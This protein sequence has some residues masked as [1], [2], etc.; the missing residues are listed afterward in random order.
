MAEG[1]RPRTVGAEALVASVASRSGSRSRRTASVRFEIH[2]V[3]LRDGCEERV[4]GDPAQGLL[5]LAPVVTRKIRQRRS[6][7]VPDARCEKRPH[8]GVGREGKKMLLGFGRLQAFR[9]LSTDFRLRGS[10]RELE[11]DLGGDPDPVAHQPLQ[12]ELADE[13]LLG[14]LCQEGELFGGDTAPDR[15]VSDRFVGG[16]RD[17]ENERRFLVEKCNGGRSLAQGRGIERQPD[18]AL[19]ARNRDR[20]F[21]SGLRRRELGIAKALRKDRIWRKDKHGPRKRRRP[22]ARIAW[23]M[24]CLAGGGRRIRD[25]PTG[26]DAEKCCR[27]GCQHQRQTG[28][29]LWSRSHWRRL[30]Q[31]NGGRRRGCE[32]QSRTP[33]D[34]ADGAAR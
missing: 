10:K 2:R 15:I 21:D 28:Q 23:H 25:G 4:V 33:A 8:F 14:S 24:E 30:S 6:S 9:R 11:P 31:P 5:A 1:L 13:W 18:L 34:A 16:V 12:N 17:D 29:G 3:S 22:L 27:R 19:R 20:R 32:R 7:V 26:P